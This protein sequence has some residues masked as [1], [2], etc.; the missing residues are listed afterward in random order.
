MYD[1][2][3]HQTVSRTFAGRNNPVQIAKDASNLIGAIVKDI[4]ALTPSLLK[5][6]YTKEE[7]GAA[8]KVLTEKYLPK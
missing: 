2:K 6:G 3:I 1:T 7:I 4:N 8:Q 5:A